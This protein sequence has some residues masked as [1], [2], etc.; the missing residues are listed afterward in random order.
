MACGFGF[1]VVAAALSAWS[2]APELMP[3]PWGTLG[4][5]AP[6][7]AGV[8]LLRSAAYFHGAGGG[9]AAAVLTVWA[10]LGVALVMVGDTRGWL[11]GARRD[12]DGALTEPA[13]FPGIPLPVAAPPAVPGAA[14][15]AVRAGL[16][17]GPA[18]G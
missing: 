10:A 7:G 15:G 3:A 14:G 9:D 12:E 17:G 1:F 18:A 11:G 2:S 8:T 4:Q 13:G 5:L 16:P 6:P